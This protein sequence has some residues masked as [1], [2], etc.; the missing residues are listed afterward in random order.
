MSLSPKSLKL[1]AKQS[2]QTAVPPVFLVTLLFLALTDVLSEV[3]YAF[4]P[5][6]TSH[7]PLQAI[8]LFLSVLLLLFRIIMSFGYSSWALQIARKENA[9]MSSLLDGFGMVGSVLFLK[10]HTVLSMLTRMMLLSTAY[11][12]LS[13][14]IIL[15]IPSSFTAIFFLLL[16]VA[17]VLGLQVIEIQF[18]LIPFRLCDHPEE[19]CTHAFLNALKMT[20][21]NLQ[22]LVKLYLSFWPWYLL[23]FLISACAVALS[24]SPMLPELSGMW[25]T[26]MEDMSQLILSVE[27]AISSALSSPVLSLVSIP[28]LT[29]FLPYR[30]ISIANFYRTLNGELAQTGDSISF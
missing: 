6:G 18:S 19:G 11:V 26:D 23:Q 29:F 16:T 10:I 8:P 30:T 15:V 28:L 17:Y 5:V 7:D 20:H 9:G 12:L 13:M 25:M 4:T 2:M 24:V 3:V 21:G 22:P 14:G 27:Y 1:A